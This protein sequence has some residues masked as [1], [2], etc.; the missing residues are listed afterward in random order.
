MDTYS[1]IYTHPLF[2][3]LS[4]SAAGQLAEIFTE[5]TCDEGAVL[6]YKNDGKGALYI[7]LEGEF[8]SAS[9]DNSQKD[10]FFP[11]DFTD[12]QD[13]FDNTT[14]EQTLI[15][16]SSGRYLKTERESL[17][18][19]LGR[20]KKSDYNKL[21]GRLK[22]GK[23]ESSLKK[24]AS[25]DNALTWRKSGF[26]LVERLQYPFLIL[27]AMTV[28]SMSSVSFPY[29]NWFYKA[30]SLM[31]FIYSALCLIL[32]LAEKY[33]LRGSEL[34][35]VRFSLNPP[36]LRQITLPV[37]QICGIMVQKKKL[38]NR[39][40]NVGNLHIQTAAGTV[41]L[42][43][44]LDRPQKIEQEISQ[45]LATRSNRMKDRD[46]VE[47]RKRIENH[48]EVREDIHSS[49]KSQEESQSPGEVLFRKSGIYLFFSIW[50]QIL[51]IGS[52]SFLIWLFRDSGGT[53]LLL[54]LIPF[55]AIMLW[56]VQDWRNDLY[57]VAGG[58]I[59][60][61]NR[62]PF[63]KSETSNL[64]DIGFVTNVKA[65]K[66]G[67]LRYLFN[68]GDVEIET[69]GGK[70][71]FE[72]VADPVSVQRTLLQQRELWKEEDFKKERDRQ[73]ND[74]LV[75]SEIYK[76]AEEQNRLNRLTPPC[77]GGRKQGV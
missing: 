30:A 20:L 50:W 2:F 65:E 18:A 66:K 38:K 43:E 46:R 16:R 7:F 11:G 34:T 1:D 55:I 3:G 72:T 36:G 56:R 12:P 25:N 76:Q 49:E 67:F 4:S 32:W 15:S 58:K 39:F 42:M 70:L 6:Y 29:Q 22:I 31:I 23:N 45:Y 21:R 59:I 37:D 62:K 61:I 26:F 33:S 52:V 28:L 13:I 51:A 53:Y 5:Y 17:V 73:F 27:I 69:A 57:K 75:Y 9:A 10:F 24:P 74:F 41:L 64:A 19:L 44:H 47:I 54:T 35:S 14:H 8:C 63:G 68:Y 71:V 60:D 48:F 40:F 77:G